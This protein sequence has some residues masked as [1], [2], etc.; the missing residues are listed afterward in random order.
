[1]KKSIPAERRRLRAEAKRRT[2]EV[3]PQLKSSIR[4]AKAQKKVRGRQCRSEAKRA[5][6]ALKAR[7]RKARTALAARVRKLNDKLKQS[8]K[9]CK[10]AGKS[11]STSA[12]EKSLAALAQ[13]REAIAELKRRASMMRSESHRKGGFKAAEQR[14]E[15][16]DEVSRELPDD[17]A[18]R[19]LWA[20]KKS[21]IRATPHASRAEK[22]FEYVHD[23]PH[24]LDEMRAKVEHEYE[25]DAERL[26][27]EL[28]EQ[29]ADPTACPNAHLATVA[30]CEK[31][32][33]SVPF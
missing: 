11:E 7:A 5:Q 20:A 33:G 25:R 14:Q 17:P 19:K 6:A 27:A 4:E 13:E 28:A 16:D 10:A 9:V 3:L 12:L 2:R 24:A 22:F 21:T 1:M 15:S 18:W 8:A 30:E 29:Q 32:L 31:L 26:F 23:H